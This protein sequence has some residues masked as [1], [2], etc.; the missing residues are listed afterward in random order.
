MTEI[1]KEHFDEQ[2][3]RLA[4]KDDITEQLRRFATKKELVEQTDA[5]AR[6]T[7]STFETFQAEYLDPAIVEI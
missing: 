4:T 2:I 3:R 5:V 1:T 7:K 6:I